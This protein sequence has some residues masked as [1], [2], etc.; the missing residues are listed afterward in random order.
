M[1]FPSLGSAVKQNITAFR[2][3]FVY[4]KQDGK[5]QLF[6]ID[7]F[8]AVLWEPIFFLCSSLPY[9][10]GTQSWTPCT[11]HFDFK[12][13]WQKKAFKFTAG[14][15]SSEINR[16]VTAYSYN[17]SDPKSKTPW[18]GE[19]EKWHELWWRQPYMIII[20]NDLQVKCPGWDYQQ[21]HSLVGTNYKSCPEDELSLV[22]VLS[23]QRSCQSM[24]CV[25]NPLWLEPAVLWWLQN[26]SESKGGISPKFQWT[27]EQGRK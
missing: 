19:E 21:I 22:R 3:S 20:K 2:R 4:R 6:V 16:A 11:F 15:S 13:F 24:R 1:F 8:A 12:P 14:Y 26:R 9:N 18:Q 17:E 27:P 25:P 10:E 5:I 7:S 23:F